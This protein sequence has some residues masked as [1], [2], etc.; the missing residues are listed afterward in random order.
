VG[1]ASGYVGSALVPEL[2]RNGHQV[3]RLVRGTTRSADALSWD[4]A[5]GSVDL[6][7]L[8]GVDAG[9]V[10]N[11]ANVGTRR[12]T[13]AYKATLLRS[14]V[15]PVRTLS[16]AFAALDPAPRVLLSNSAS[17]FYGD[18]GDAPVDE[19]APQ[20]VG[21]TARMAA[22]WEAAADP[23]R[24]AG[25]RVVH[26]RLNL[27]LGP[28]G[29]DTAGGRLAAVVRFGLGAR[30][31][32]GN[33]LWSVVALADLVR[34]TEFLVTDDTVEGPVNVT[35]PETNRS[36]DVMRALGRALH[37]PTPWVAPGPVVRLL[38]GEFAHEMLAN[39]GLSPNRLLSTGFRLEYP[40]VDAVVR[41]TLGR[42]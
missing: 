27:V 19:S 32:S 11:G 36:I 35:V 4:P 6:D 38:L 9:I 8:Q 20:G 1:G 13:T 18:T 17:G 22:E 15:D 5:R 7:A 42:T 26:P 24:K 14:R 2:R 21:F 28:G 40:D 12:W 16:E 3:V 33:Q 23:A 41:Y 39:Q 34:A 25:I 10:L 37:R 30:L 31:G 29:F